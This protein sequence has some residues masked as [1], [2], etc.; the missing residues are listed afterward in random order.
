MAAAWYRFRAELRGSWRSHALAAVFLA[1]VFGGSLTAF[2]GAR[3][4]VSAMPRLVEQTAA[5]DVLVNPDQGTFSRITPERLAALPEVAASGVVW[6]MFAVPALPDGNP[7]FETGMITLAAT[8]GAGYDIG[9][10][11]VVEGRMPDPDDPD[12]VLLS[13]GLAQHY[14]VEPGDRLPLLT[15]TMAEL[16][17]WEAAGGEGEMPFRTG[18]VTVAG[19]GYFADEV[20]VEDGFADE[21]ITFTPAFYERHR[22]GV[23]F[24]GGDVRV[25]P[26]VTPREFEAAVQALAPDEAV[27]FRWTATAVD[28]FQTAVRPQAVA[29][30]AFGGVLALVGLF[31]FGL[32]LTRHADRTTAERGLAAAMGMPRRSLIGIGTL[33]G[34]GV[35][36]ATALGSVIVAVVLSPLT[37]VGP[38]RRAEPDPGVA[39]DMLVLAVGLSVLA[40]LGAVLGGVTARM[41]NRRVAGPAASA[42]PSRLADLAARMGFAPPAVVGAR[43]A[44]DAGR[45]AS[46]VP[47]RMTLLGA[48]VAVAAV[49]AAATFTA[50]LHRVVSTPELYGS[51]W[52]A[53]AFIALPPDD[54]DG[55]E[56]FADADGVLA[57]FV[58]AALA[59]LDRIPQVEGVSVATFSQIPAGTGS[60]P[61]F[62]IDPVRGAAHP[63]LVEGRLPQRP[64]ELVLGTRT[65][66]QLGLGVGGV[67]AAGDRRLDVVGRALFPGF[68]AYPGQDKTALGDGAWLTPAGLAG[69]GSVFE[70]RTLLVDV[71]EGADAEALLAD[72]LPTLPGDDP[73]VVFDRFRPVEIDTL[74]RVR[75]TPTVLAFVLA[76]LGVVGVSATLVAGI[77]RRR[78]MLA[79]VRVLG[80]TSHQV[81]ATLVWNAAIVAA[82]AVAL[83]IPL[84]VA[85]GRWSWEGV[86]ERLGGEAAAA[87]P[88]GLALA[89]VAATFATTLLASLFSTRSATRI[90]PAVV[91]RSE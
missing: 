18:E 1:L 73:Q 77:R 36:A 67:F 68:A 23:G 63:T 6:G 90:R 44:V 83:G 12:G 21:R 7:D 25:A 61:A 15:L 49:V 20:E 22:D 9:R 29:L 13:E 76:L 48:V 41:A 91:L 51:N 11:V 31:G 3:R 46:Q 45:G 86:I 84:G 55:P 64:D 58:D 32:V 60:V 62:G 69:V 89:A 88:W 10:P 17:A 28:R 39:V 19:V 59:D 14:G 85:A 37:P 66:R 40:A 57:G 42:L 72:F 35:G 33:H 34:V 26:G 27:A 54:V 47:V 16:E 75:S 74:Q 78:R 30:A 53:T 56:S 82:V 24:W 8:E 65:L 87:V 70:G 71:A 43:M 4:T 2:A 79:L 80:F 38:A 52:D 81:R 50:S 5:A